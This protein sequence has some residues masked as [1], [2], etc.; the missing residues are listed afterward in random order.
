MEMDQT[1]HNRSTS[2]SY[3][4]RARSAE[5]ETKAVAL[6]AS[7]TRKKLMIF[8]HL[9]FEIAFKGFITAGV[10]NIRKL[11]GSGLF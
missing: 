1:P 8:E 5:R 7:C 9:S 11:E 4:H 3:K 2:V 10:S 6:G